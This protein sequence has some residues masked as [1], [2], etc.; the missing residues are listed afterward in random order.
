MNSQSASILEYSKMYKY[1]L[2][3]IEIVHSKTGENSTHG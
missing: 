2:E 3:S 1:K